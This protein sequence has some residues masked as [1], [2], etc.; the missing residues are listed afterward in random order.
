MK[1]SL[2]LLALAVVLVVLVGCA[3]GPNTFVDTP[4]EAGEV[5]GFWLGLW[6]GIIAPITFV[7][8]LFNESVG[9]YAI[10]NNGGWYNAGFL[11]GLGAVWGGGGSGASRRRRSK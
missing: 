2:V 4:N 11:F 8:S 5:A 7:V 9:M 10:H 3:A 6:H 1:R